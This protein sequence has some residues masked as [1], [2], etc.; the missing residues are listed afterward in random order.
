MKA[1]TEPFTDAELLAARRTVLSFEI[2]AQRHL[3][4]FEKTG[5]DLDLAKASQALAISAYAQIQLTGVQ[6]D[7]GCAVVSNKI[8]AHP[9]K[10]RINSLR[11]WAD[12]NKIGDFTAALDEKNI[13]QFIEANGGRETMMTMLAGYKNLPNDHTHQFLEDDFAGKGK[14][15][16]KNG[17]GNIPVCFVVIR[18]Y[19]C[20]QR[21][22]SNSLY[23]T[24]NGRA[25]PNG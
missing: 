24:V 4:K 15:N 14:A 3:K 19:S 12:T 11:T 9:G 1:V 25:F 2:L 10:G 22:W 7:L 8:I 20:I 18:C 21:C 5:T 16:T 23:G 17:Y 6:E 13:A